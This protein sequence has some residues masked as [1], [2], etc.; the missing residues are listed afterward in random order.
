MSNLLKKIKPHQNPFLL[1]LPFLVLYIGI[2]IVFREKTMWG[3]EIRYDTFAHNILHGYYS[4]APPFV[5]LINGPGYPL[6]IAPF[7][8]VGLPY[9]AI[10]LLNALFYYLSVV[11]LFKALQKIAPFRY[12][13]VFSLFWA[14]YYNSFQDIYR[15]LTEPFTCFLVS[16][17]LFC[18]INVF[19]KKISKSKRKYF[20]LSGILIGYLVLTKVAFG[21]VLLFML[22]GFGVLSVFNKHSQ[23]YRRGFFILLIGF[24]ITIPYLLYTYY[25]TG[26]MFYWSN[27]GGD[28]LYW[29][30]TPYENEYGDW[31]GYPDSTGYDMKDNHSIYDSLGAHHREDMKYIYS[32]KGIDRDDAFKRI[33]IRNIKSHPVK[34]IR[35]C[36]SNLGRVLFNYPYSYK[37]QDD[38]NL[39]R[40]PL[41]GFLLVLSLFCLIPTFINWRKIDFGIRLLLFMVL[42]Y[43]G[44]S[45]LVSG[46]ARV[47]TV[48]V[49]ILIAWISYTLARSAKYKVKYENNPDL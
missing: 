36:I 31:H 33:A 14:C 35:N 6:L 41:N 1:F 39:I 32:F 3:D 17:L 16:L 37:Y 46:F 20:F 21:Y 27:A 25:L 49:P 10:V 40:L 2:I 47:F 28:S 5:N 23:N 26:K 43:L 42:L 48:I 34:Y 45:V 15:M 44:E 4:P 24:G 12:A 38:K 29:M 13:L 11:F 30:T 22:A 19:D 7:F 8:A 18:T 9:L